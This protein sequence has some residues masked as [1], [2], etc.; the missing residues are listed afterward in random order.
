MGASV[1]TKNKTFDPLSQRLKP[2]GK[3]SHWVADLYSNDPADGMC[4]HNAILE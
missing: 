1:K 4:L 2:K 3:T